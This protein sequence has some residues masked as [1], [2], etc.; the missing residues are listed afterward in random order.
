MEEMPDDFYI[1]MNPNN[2]IELM[3]DEKI[4]LFTCKV[5]EIK[6]DNIETKSKINLNSAQ[7]EIK[8]YL[9]TIFPKRELSDNLKLSE[10]LAKSFCVKIQLKKKHIEPSI[11][12]FLLID[13]DDTLMLSNENVNHLGR[14]LM[15]AYN[16]KLSKTKIT[17]SEMMNEA[18]KNIKRNKLNIIEEYC[19]FNNGE[20]MISYFKGF[21]RLQT[22]KEYP[23]PEMI[24]LINILASITKLEFNLEK[25]DKVTFNYFT[26]LSLN[27]E[28]IF[29][30][31][32]NVDI[33][34]TNDKLLKMLYHRFSK[35]LNTIEYQCHKNI[36]KISFNYP[37][38]FTK[39]TDFN[40]NH[41]M[42]REEIDSRSN[43]NESRGSFSKMTT[44]ISSN[45]GGDSEYVQLEYSTEDGISGKGGHYMEILKQYQIGF[46]YLIISI[47]MIT[48]LKGIT[49][50][51]FA[52]SETFKQ[53]IIKV[54]NKVNQISFKD[55]DLIKPFSYLTKLTELNLEFNSLDYVSFEKMSQ[56]IILNS[57]LNK[58]HLSLFLP[59]A[60][61]S[62]V[63]L[64]KLL[65]S[66]DNNWKDLF[67]K[68]KNEINN[69]S[70]DDNI[71]NMVIDHVLNP[72]TSNITF[73][74]W[75]IQKQKALRELNIVI[76]QPC[77]L[78][79]HDKYSWVLLKFVLNILL[80][81][82]DQESNYQKAK[83]VVPFLKFDNRSN[84]YMH[85]FIELIR[86]NQPKHQLKY[87]TFQ[88]QLYEIVNIGH[89][90]SHNLIELHIGDFDAKSFEY[91][92]RSLIRGSFYSESH[93][94]IIGL[95]LL[96][97]VSTYAT[98]K[99]PLLNLLHLSITS[100][101]RLYFRTNLFMTIKLFRDILGNMTYSF[102]K[103]LFFEFDLK[104]E[105][106]MK[107][108]NEVTYSYYITPD[109]TPCLNY[110]KKRLNYDD[111]KFNCL[112]KSS[113]KQCEGGLRISY[114]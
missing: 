105:D 104:S 87:F 109:I 5:A 108:S 25:I 112:V 14:I 28:W 24:F 17:T 83:L 77:I 23:P 96:P 46:E 27:I 11:S 42:L 50:L 4:F 13:K 74:F 59:E 62:P 66:I 10:S 71:D 111:H 12:H 69:N 72:Y 21:R 88:I 9:N 55:F 93:L 30:S 43:L 79:N 31:V 91:F 85:D 76:I 80:L 89:L 86:F 49:K 2:T 51:S 53:E 38:L 99:T 39:R 35:D 37:M 1:D 40:A 110:F 82:N 52:F 67:R 44:F 6:S 7:G 19:E 78:I 90:L 106:I 58:L 70:Q 29:Q 98:I 15:Y 114:K 95:G 94:K 8:N 102:I 56:L 54:M 73:L 41:Y 65:L 97:T 84:S 103:E 20:L 45:S 22:N 57:Y 60:H 107:N 47:D 26:I 36:R 18:I 32:N 92:V 33:S 3:P 64:F 48:H 75:A 61:Y 101:E 81:I 113:F 63:G 34:I 16:K 100:L 68:N